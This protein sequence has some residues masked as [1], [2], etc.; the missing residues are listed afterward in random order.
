M[1]FLCLAEAASELPQDTA[2]IWNEAPG[3]PSLTCAFIEILIIIPIF[4]SKMLRL[5]LDLIEIITFMA[6]IFFFPFNSLFGIMVIGIIYGAQLT[7][8][9][10][11]ITLDFL[12]NYISSFCPNIFESL[13]NILNAISWFSRIQLV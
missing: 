11:L 4:I 13:D 10:C 3:D 9:I 5:G 8:D 6:R 2:I 12:V 1:Y 7:T